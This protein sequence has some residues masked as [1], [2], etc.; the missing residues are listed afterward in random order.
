MNSINVMV[1]FI[2][3]PDQMKKIIYKSFLT[4]NGYNDFKFFKSYISVKS[5]YFKSRS[6]G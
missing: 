4:N 6:R 5:K 1:W 2:E 3:T